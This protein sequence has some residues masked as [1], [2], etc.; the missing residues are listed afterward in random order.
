MRFRVIKSRF[1]MELEYIM[2]ET[3]MKGKIEITIEPQGEM[4]LINKE[5]VDNVKKALPPSAITGTFAKSLFP[6]YLGDFMKNANHDYVLKPNPKGGKEYLIVSANKKGLIKDTSDKITPNM[7]ENIKF[8]RIDRTTLPNTIKELGI[9]DAIP[10]DGT[11]FTISGFYYDGRMNIL[12]R[13]IVFK[14]VDK[15]LSFLNVFTPGDIIMVPRDKVT[16]IDGFYMTN[17]SLADQKTDKS[18]YE[19][20]GDDYGM[21][22]GKY[23]NGRPWAN[24]NNISTT[25]LSPDA[26]IATQPGRQPG[27]NIGG[28]AMFVTNGRAYSFGG[29]R[30]DF[31]QLDNSAYMSMIDSAGALTG[32]NP[33]TPLPRVKVFARACAW[34][35]YIHIIGGTSSYAEGNRPSDIFRAKMNPDGTIGKWETLDVKLPRT[36]CAPAV[37]VAGRR[38]YVAGG[39]VPTGKWETHPKFGTMPVNQHNSYV[40][41][42]NIDKEGKIGNFQVCDSIRGGRECH[43]TSNKGKFAMISGWRHD[44][45]QSTSTMLPIG[46]LDR[47]KVTKGPKPTELMYTMVPFR[48][49]DTTTFFIDSGGRSEGYPTAA[50][51]STGI[52]MATVNQTSNDISQLTNVK[53]LYDDGH[54]RVYFDTL[55]TSSRI[56]V[57][58]GVTT[59]G[60]YNDPNQGEGIIVR[61]PY[62]VY[63]GGKNNYMPYMDGTKNLEDIPKG[64]FKLPT[65]PDEKYLIDGKEVWYRFFIKR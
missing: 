26:K 5:Y 63:S 35:G 57:I 42:A 25:A 48:V 6:E 59:G 13:P 11:G 34:A 28:S 37:W 64:K 3:H 52:N 14:D 8:E 2:Y 41:Y 1:T 21:D 43:L 17:G 23:G 39:H 54:N 30:G 9:T 22:F 24:L 46:H 32:W 18:L 19:V 29:Y 47:F 55:V 15:D 7:W 20:C 40:Y 36:L 62:L 31:T 50:L 58:G 65:I 60:T 53:T 51:A 33:T 45:G 49:A 27:R 61:D 10:L 38:L 4:D 16:N 44:L 12:K 56:C